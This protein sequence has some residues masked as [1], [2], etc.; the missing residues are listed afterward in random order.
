MWSR[1]GVYH[2]QCSA[3]YMQSVQLARCF[4]WKRAKLESVP[5]G[6]TLGIWAGGSCGHLLQRK[7]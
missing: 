1:P 7:I 6:L 2:K 3:D 4:Q 5:S